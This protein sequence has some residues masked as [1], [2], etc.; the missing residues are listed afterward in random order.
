[1]IYFRRSS[2]WTTLLLWLWFE[3]C[4]TGAD[5]KND[6]REEKD[7]PHSRQKRLLWI[8]SDGRL[9]LPPGTKLTIT[10]SLSMPFVRYPPEGFMSNMSISLPFTIDFNT[11]GLTDNQNPFG[12]FPQILARSMGRQ[13]GSAL[14]DY[15]SQLMRG[16]RSTRSV[17]TLPK[18]IHSYFQGGERALMFTVVEDLLTNFGMNGKACLL[19]AICEVHGHKSIHTFGFLG[20]FIQLFFTASKSTYADLMNDYV[21]AETIG[22]QSKEC[23]PYFKECPKS[24]F[25][26]NHNYSE[27]DLSPDDEDEDGESV[28]ANNDGDDYGNGNEVDDGRK[29]SSSA[30]GGLKVTVNPTPLAM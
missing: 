27:N 6:M 1:M 4:V 13:T 26:N 17:P 8:T 23:Y 9:A 30:S 2:L 24:L 18:P 22:K 29:K 20:E 7:K 16:R 3:N 19:R 12:A 28:S 15:V 25:T 11:L 5:D 14:V 21:T 10:P